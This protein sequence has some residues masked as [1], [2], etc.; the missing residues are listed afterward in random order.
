MLAKFVPLVPIRNPPGAL[1]AQAALV[2][3]TLKLLK[4]PFA[5]SAPRD[6]ILREARHRAQNVQ[7]VTPLW[8]KGARAVQLALQERTLRKRVMPALFAPM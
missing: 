1:L 6:F 3:T 4:L 2:D 8:R 5:L 7:M